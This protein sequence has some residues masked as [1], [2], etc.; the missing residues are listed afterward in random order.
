[1]KSK[2]QIFQQIVEGL[3]G[4]VLMFNEAL[5]LDYMNPAGEMLFEISAKRIQGLTLEEVFPNND[6][7]V[8]A[9]HKA[10]NTG[11]PFTEREIVL[12]L[13]IMRTTCV[14]CSVTPLF[15]SPL[16]KTLLVEL[17]PTERVM[18]ISREENQF[19][20][21]N[22]IRALI[23]GLAHEVKNPLGGLR[24]AAQLLERELPDESLKEYT[25]III[26]E[27]DRLRNLV[28]RMLGPNS[29]PQR[30]P[31]NIH[32]VLEHVRQLMEVDVSDSVILKKDYDPSIPEISADRD[33]L[34]QAI[35]NIVRNAIQAV[36]E[37]GV[38]TL[39]TRALRQFTIGH[40]RHKLVCRVDII[41][42]GPGIPEEAIESIFYPMVSHR[43]EGTG[44]GLSI[45]QTLIQQ[46]E[47]I[48]ICES[49]PGNTV[50]SVL[51]PVDADIRKTYT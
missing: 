49:Q 21:V 5:K 28:D 35:L 48:I 45:A 46:H 18:R 16:G 36:G 40:I 1:M 24:G 30:I 10:Y 17:N 31:L 7:L 19:S 27:A 20:Q 2:H 26:G 47:G 9:M 41:D 51:L 6:A 14:D 22:A 13:P 42:N 15:D 23:R 8:I 50:F 4:G 34:I 11:R 38:I 25:N 32:E 12:A 29:V 39:R 43:P 33:L 44:L 37:S 3:S